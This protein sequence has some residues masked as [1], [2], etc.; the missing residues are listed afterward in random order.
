MDFLDFF[1]EYGGHFN[2]HL[3]NCMNMYIN[4]KPCMCLGYECVGLT[5]K[6]GIQLIRVLTSFKYLIIHFRLLFIIPHSPPCG[7]YILNVLC[8]EAYGFFNGIS[9]CHVTLQLCHIS[10]IPF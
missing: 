8:I 1:Y 7:L 5:L 2:L 3:P 10:H 6:V 9:I 4:T